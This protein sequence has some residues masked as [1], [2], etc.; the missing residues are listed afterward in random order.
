[1]LSRSVSENSIWLQAALFPPGCTLVSTIKQTSPASPSLP[2]EKIARSRADDGIL[3]HAP[4]SRDSA[5]VG[6]IE[7]ESTNIVRVNK[8]EAISEA[9]GATA[10][11]SEVAHQEALTPFVC[12]GFV[13]VIE[14]T[15]RLV[16]SSG[17]HRSQELETFS[18]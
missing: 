16:N 6:R 5:D 9:L 1:M 14:F 3:R 18:R 8:H 2:D 13:S 12:I 4:S 11:S 7:W 17:A 15:R 10:T